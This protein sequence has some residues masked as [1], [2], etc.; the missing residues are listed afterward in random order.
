MII[1]IRDG[2]GIGS[3]ATNCLHLT[4]LN[5]CYFVALIGSISIFYRKAL[6][7]GLLKFVK[8]VIFMA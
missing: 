5:F 6:F 1:N 2:S 7:E 3:V 4:V 8:F